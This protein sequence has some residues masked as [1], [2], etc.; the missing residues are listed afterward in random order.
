MNIG[1]DL[2][3][4]TN[5]QGIEVYAEHTIQEMTSLFPQHHLFLFIQKSIFHKFTFPN[6]TNLTVIPLGNQ[7]GH[8]GLVLTQQGILPWL[9]IHYKISILYSPSPF[10]SFFS[11]TKKVITV[12]DAAYE[13][14]PEY[15]NIFYKLYLRS[16]LFL[17]RFLCQ[18]IV[19]VSHF[20]KNELRNHYKFSENSIFVIPGGPPDPSIKIKETSSVLD[21]FSL[22]NPFFF[23]IGTTRPRKNLHGLLLA[24]QQF[25]KNHPNIKLVL[26]GTVDNSFEDIQD[27]IQRLKI[28]SSVR[29]LG[30]ISEQEKI[31]LYQSCV[32]FVFPSL[33][34]G[35][36]LPILEAQQY[37]APVITSNT[38][39][40]PE[41][42]GETVY[43]IDPTNNAELAKA[44]EILLRDS[45]LRENLIRCGH[46]NILRFS[47]KRTAIQLE[48]LLRN[49][50]YE[51]T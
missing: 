26:A 6:C 51:Q 50:S 1:I 18:S 36:G 14:F 2:T 28:E 3:T 10:F 8:L 42:A 21:R 22:K 29:Q 44:M 30:F 7:L 9:A 38:T 40:I 23:Y 17:S 43:Y 45:R 34:E 47:W 46:E 27:M 16:S 11:P 48:S 15:R 20:S 13:H 32:A 19:T 4:S 39:A 24:F 33:Y 5:Y 37:G 35:F 12:H 31:A 25:Q 41:T 49:V